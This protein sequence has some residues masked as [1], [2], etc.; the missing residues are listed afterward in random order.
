P[1][2]QW[3]VA[4]ELRRR[5]KRRFDREN[6]EIPFPHQKLVWDGESPP[7]QTVK[8]TAGA[9]DDGEADDEDT[10]AAAGTAGHA[11]GDHATEDEEA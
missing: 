2:K 8:L 1:L 4:R 5:L 6:I 3:D 9:I 11:H 7:P 10:G